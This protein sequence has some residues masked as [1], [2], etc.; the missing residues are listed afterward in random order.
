MEKRCSQKIG[1]TAKI[2]LA[3]WDMW[4]FGGMWRG[5]MLMYHWSFG[6]GKQWPCSY[7][8]DQGQGQ[9][10]ADNSD[11][12]LCCLDLGLKPRNW[13][14]TFIMWPL[15]FSR[16][17]MWPALCVLVS[18]TCSLSPQHPPERNGEVQICQKVSHECC[19]T[20]EEWPQTERRERER[21][22]E[23]TEKGRR[24]K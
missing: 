9:D 22:R 16:C 14:F 5:L 7:W 24:R 1:Y 13:P 17:Q 21:E 8:S 6:W 19:F 2:Y 15:A 23:S 18:P 10:E 20:W 3:V 4:G 12:D 11:T